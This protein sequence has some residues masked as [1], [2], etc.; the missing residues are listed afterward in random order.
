MV[1]HGHQL[2]IGM[3]QLNKKMISIENMEF[4][5]IYA[6]NKGTDADNMDGEIDGVGGVLRMMVVR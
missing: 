3:L 1:V 2:Q 6:V 4:A 5:A